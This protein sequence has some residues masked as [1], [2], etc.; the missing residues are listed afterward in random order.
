MT[1]QITLG[2][3]SDELAQ[4][5]TKKKEFLNRI[6]RIVPWTE[7]LKIIEPHYYKGERGNKT[8][9]KELM[10]R[11]CICYKTCTIYQ[12]CKQQSR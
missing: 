7:W 11:G 9:D 5:K 1:N 2:K 3:L 12:I 8:Y 10:L 6:D 4:A